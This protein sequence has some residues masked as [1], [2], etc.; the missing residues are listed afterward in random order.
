MKHAGTQLLETKRLVLRKYDSSDAD[1]MYRNWVTDPEVC[2]FWQWEPHRNIG[3]TKTLLRGWIQEYGKP[4]NYHWTIELK[5]TSQ[6][7]G[8]IYFSDIDDTDNSLSVHYALSRK[9]WGMGI[10]TEACRC[11]L[12]FAFTVLG[13]ERI[14]SYHHAENPA[15]GRVM[16][17][18][19]MHYTKTEEKRFPE[20]E[21]ISGKY[22]YYEVSYQDWKTDG[23]VLK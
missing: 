13:A 16:Q 21:R 14:F 20:C 23:K 17:K 4:D 2:R 5:S 18:S 22:L 9:Y 6:V 11:V 15:S 7:I 12:D 19:G 10:M 8:Y 3:E 1:D